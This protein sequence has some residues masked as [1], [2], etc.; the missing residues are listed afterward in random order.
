MGHRCSFLFGTPAGYDSIPS[1]TFRKPILSTDSC[2]CILLCLALDQ[3]ALFIKT[4]L[5][6]SKGRNLSIKEIFNQN[7]SDVIGS[8][9]KKILI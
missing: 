3:N 7:I 6:N 5:F 2:P 8:E 4:L 1:L 9:L